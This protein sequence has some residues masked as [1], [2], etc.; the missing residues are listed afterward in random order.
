MSP[1]FQRGMP[2]FI[3]FCYEQRMKKDKDGNSADSKPKQKLQDHT[4]HDGDNLVK[5]TPILKD[6]HC[7]AGD[8]VHVD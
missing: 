8:E 6:N 2:Q 3:A 4:C 7:T 5:V 1:R